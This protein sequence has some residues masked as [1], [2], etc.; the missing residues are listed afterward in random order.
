MLLFCGSKIAALPFEDGRG[1]YFGTTR[2][3]FRMVAKY[4]DYGKKYLN[5]GYGKAEAVFSGLRFL[6]YVFFVLTLFPGTI[7]PISY[8]IT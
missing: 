8:D 2:M 1:G 6:G 7:T 3:L 4:L 5:Y